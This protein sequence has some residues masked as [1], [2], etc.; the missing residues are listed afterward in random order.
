MTKKI[1]VLVVN[2]V[3]GFGLFQYLET[4]FENKIPFK[5]FA[6]SDSVSVRT[7]SGIALQTDAVI[8]ELKGHEKEY[9]ALVFACGDAMP[10][11]ADN[12]DKPYNQDL[13]AVVKTFNDKGKIIIGH[14]AVAMLFDIVG[15]GEGKRVAVH[16][17]GKPHLKKTIGTDE[18]YVIDGNLYTAQTENTI[19]ALMPAVLKK[20]A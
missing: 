8:A 6:V 7:N 1:A 15:I 14:C 18:K 2:P 3:N 19:S 13:L 20:L 16:P 5:T 9:D 17:F 10:V 11:F 12:I 4:F